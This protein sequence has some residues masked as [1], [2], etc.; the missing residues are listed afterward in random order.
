MK[1]QETCVDSGR[2]AW[3]W[4]R[5]KQSNRANYLQEEE[6]EEEEQPEEV[7]TMYSIE[8]PQPQVPPITQM[9]LVN[10]YPVKFEIDTGCSVTVLSQVEYGKMEAKKKLPK[11]KTSSLSLKTYTG[12]SVNVLGTTKVEVKHKGLTKEL[13]AVVVAGVGPNL[14]G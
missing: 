9:L 4:G 1:P 2:K 3:K 6:E 13:T 5:G 8:T 11:L 7:F 12:Q 14:L 10:E